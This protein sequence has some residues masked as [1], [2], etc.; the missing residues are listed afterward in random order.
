MNLHRVFRRFETCCTQIEG[1]LSEAMA[2]RYT[3]RPAFSVYSALA[4]IRLHDFWT[5][6]CRQLVFCSCSGSCTTLSGTALPRSP[7]V[8]CSLDPIEWLRI[9]WTSTGKRMGNT[10]EPDWYLPD[11]CLRAARLLGIANYATVFNA[12]SAVLVTDQVRFTRNAVVH[13]LPVT[14][15]RFRAMT[16]RLGFGVNVSPL[17]F[18]Y[19]RLGGT[20]PMLIDSWIS[21]LQLCIAAAIR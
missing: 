9:N 21:E 11:Q 16:A 14:Y 13:S 10:W 17:E 2:F 6:Q 1:L 15:S 8:P 18:M 20:G 3:N 4:V 19:C 12:L 5:A 7:V